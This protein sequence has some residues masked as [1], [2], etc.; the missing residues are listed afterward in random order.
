[1]K[2]NQTE[3]SVTVTLKPVQLQMITWYTLCNIPELPL[4][5]SEL[6]DKNNQP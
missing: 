6:K 1:M 3:R 2:T 5:V 4:G